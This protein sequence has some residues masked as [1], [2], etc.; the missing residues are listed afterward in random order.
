MAPPPP[1]TLIHTESGTTEA[2]DPRAPKLKVTHTSC[3]MMQQV[4]GNE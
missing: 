4:M 2:L 1:H 3:L